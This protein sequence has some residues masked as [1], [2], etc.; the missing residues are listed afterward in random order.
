[1]GEKGIGNHPG[2]W[3]A[4]HDD[5]REKGFEITTNPREAHNSDTGQNAY[6]DQDK[7]QWV[8]MKTSKPLTGSIWKK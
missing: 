2:M 3:R 8:D 7:G 5:I 1:M 4:I 6:W